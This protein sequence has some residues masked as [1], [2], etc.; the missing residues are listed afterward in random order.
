MDKAVD[1]FDEVGLPTS[2]RHQTRKDSLDEWWRQYRRKPSSGYRSHQVRDKS[3]GLNRYGVR[4]WGVPLR[5]Q[6]PEAEQQLQVPEAVHH[7]FSY[8]RAGT[9]RQTDGR[10]RANRARQGPVV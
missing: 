7:E 2:S 4:P 8:Q 1:G 5:D 6:G 9:R 3:D 10:R